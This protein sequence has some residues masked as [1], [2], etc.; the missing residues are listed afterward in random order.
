MRRDRERGGIALVER[1]TELAD[2]GT[3]IGD[4]MIA[5]NQATL[6]LFATPI[7]R[8][9]LPETWRKSFMW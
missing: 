9:L 3:D 6:F 5:M 7:T 2:V 1:I 4:Q 8:K